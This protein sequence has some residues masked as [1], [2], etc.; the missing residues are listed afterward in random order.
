LLLCYLAFGVEAG[1]IPTAVDFGGG[2]GGQEGCSLGFE[3]EVN[4]QAIA[5][6]KSACGVEQNAMAAMGTFGIEGALKFQR[7]FEL[8]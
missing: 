2:G 7:G 4:A 6:D 5:P 1:L 3:F 8:S